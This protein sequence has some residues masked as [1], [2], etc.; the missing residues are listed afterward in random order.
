MWKHIEKRRKFEE[1]QFVWKEQK[2][3]VS[4]NMFPK[5]EKKT[6][7]KKRKRKN[8]WLLLTYIA[9]I[10]RINF[11]NCLWL[12]FDIVPV[13]ISQRSCRFVFHSMR[14][15]KWLNS[16]T[17]VIFVD[18]RTLKDLCLLFSSLKELIFHLFEF[19]LLVFPFFLPSA[20]EICHF[21][22]F[23]LLSKSDNFLKRSVK[24]KIFR[25]TFSLFFLFSRRRASFKRIQYV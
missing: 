3:K 14:R 12:L 25:E 19:F 1:I 11:R 17:F 20:N 10:C 22:F 16:P 9:C 2:K 5:W 13:N 23:F 7:N 18:T 8:P 6:V 15:F 24:S 21:F 4:W